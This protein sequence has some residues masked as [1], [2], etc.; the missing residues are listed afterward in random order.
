MGRRD[1]AAFELNERLGG[2]SELIV[3]LG[4]CQLRLMNDRRWP[5]LVLVPRHH[6][7]VEIADLPADEQPL[8]WQE[9]NRASAALHGLV[10]DLLLRRP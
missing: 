2:D 4:L 9:V 10:A 1:L 8:L 7:L 3:T 5:W 6:G